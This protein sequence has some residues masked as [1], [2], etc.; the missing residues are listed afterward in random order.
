MLY[1]KYFERYKAKTHK[2]MSLQNSP[3]PFLLCNN[4][5]AIF[6]A[7]E[8]MDDDGYLE[9][10]YPFGTCHTLFAR[11][12][13]KTPR[14][15]FVDSR[16]I[17][18]WEELVRV[19]AE[20]LAADEDAEVALAESL[21]AQFNG[22]LTPTSLSIGAGN[23]GATSGHDSF[24]VH[25]KNAIDAKEFHIKK[26]DKDVGYQR[27]AAPYWHYQ[28][29]AAPYITDSPYVELIYKRDSKDCLVVQLRNGPKVSASIDFIPENTEV[30]KVIRAEGD[31]LQWE[32]MTANCQKGTV[33]YHPGGSQASHYSVHCVNNGI[34]VIISY[35]PRVGDFLAKID[36]CEKTPDIVWSEL[37]RGFA[38]ACRANVTTSTAARIMLATLQVFKNPSSYLLGIGMG[39]AYRLS[40]TACS[41]EMR[42]QAPRRTKGKVSRNKIFVKA[43]KCTDVR[44]RLFNK[45][46]DAFQEKELWET[47]FGGEAWANIAALAI[48]L[49]S[50]IK[51]ENQ[52]ETL[53][54]FNRL[55]NAQHNTS[56]AFN[57]FIF[58]HV[59]DA[60]SKGCAADVVSNYHV[61]EALHELLVRPD[62]TKGKFNWKI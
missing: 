30:T 41:G 24:T 15:G 16:I 31:L 10:Q 57:K 42:H 29:C 47:A 40:L 36:G 27:C 17:S 52:T 33:C 21:D 4:S 43:W 44:R 60:Y 25:F 20:S 6:T 19:A 8:I 2:G 3:A 58:L 11:P 28:R 26:F 62:A 48:A 39:F 37:K 22:I 13:P 18:S 12:C 9:G 59:Y 5:H 49:Y 46:L 56:W 23:D 61:V 54:T 32:A 55:I 7:K 1:Q 51:A 45:Y 34:P 50:E 35:E 14:H 53:S 38:R